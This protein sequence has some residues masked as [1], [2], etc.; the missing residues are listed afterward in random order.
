MTRADTS[1]SGTR[2]VSSLFPPPC[3]SCISFEIQILW[4]QRS[5]SCHVR[6]RDSVLGVNAGAITPLFT[7]NAV[8]HQMGLWFGRNWYCPSE[9]S[10]KRLSQDSHY[11]GRD[12]NQGPPEYICREFPSETNCSASLVRKP[13]RKAL[14]QYSTRIFN[15]FHMTHS[16]LDSST[17]RSLQYRYNLGNLELLLYKHGWPTTEM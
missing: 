17:P 6:D 9:G 10:E 7:V 15:W 3:T 12:S 14:T 5:Q 13:S 4:L 1:G 11:P 2:G 16:N 8:Q